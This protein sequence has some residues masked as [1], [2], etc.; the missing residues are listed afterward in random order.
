MIHDPKQL[1][2]TTIRQEL[3]DFVT[4]DDLQNLVTKDDLGNLSQ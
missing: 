1:V 3:S 4:K 2:A